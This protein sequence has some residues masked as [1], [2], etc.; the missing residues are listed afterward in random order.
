VIGCILML[1]FCDD[2]M[3]SVTKEM[4]KLAILF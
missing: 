3:A 1:L 4:W 2:C